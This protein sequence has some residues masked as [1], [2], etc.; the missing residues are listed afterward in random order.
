MATFPQTSL[1]KP[2]VLESQLS[3]PR[4]EHLLSLFE[5]NSFLPAKR[6]WS[7]GWFGLPL[8]CSICDLCPAQDWVF[9]QAHCP[10]YQLLYSLLQPREHFAVSQHFQVRGKYKLKGT[11][12][13]ASSYDL[14]R[15][16]ASF[17]QIMMGRISRFLTKGLVSDTEMPCL[18]LVMGG[19]DLTM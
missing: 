1:S 18:L 16:T 17:K 15:D 13:Q 9:K 2:F 3:S 12:D 6:L 4:Q 19:R 11:S 5:G 7:V 14:S 10:S 8:N